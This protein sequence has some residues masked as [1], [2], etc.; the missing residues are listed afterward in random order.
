MTL[1]AAM[2]VGS[3]EALL[4]AAAFA[5]FAFRAGRVQGVGAAV[6]AA[7]VE[8]EITERGRSRRVEGLLPLVVG[9]STDA[10]ILLMDPDVSRRHARFEREGEAIVLTDLQSSNGTFLNGR[11]IGKSV[12]VRPGD[13]IDIGSV[14]IAVIGSTR[15]TDD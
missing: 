8:F 10:D 12:Q 1:A 7:A 11:R 9:R 2:R 5:V 13:E 4:A 6:R 3:L 15:G 14:R